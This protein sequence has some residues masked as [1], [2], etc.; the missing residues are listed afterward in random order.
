MYY[1]N[2]ASMTMRS[3]S[4]SFSYNLASDTNRCVKAKKLQF[5]ISS[6][7]ASNI[8]LI[9]LDCPHYKL[10]YQVNMLNNKQMMPP[11]MLQYV[12]SSTPPPL[13]SFSSLPSLPSTSLSLSTF[14]S[15]PSSYSSSSPPP[16]PSLYSLQSSASSSPLLRLIIASILCVSST[17]S[18][19]LRNQLT[20]SNEMASNLEVISK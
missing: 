19:L 12:T 8:H 15:T 4:N 9:W 17:T 1:H 13:M 10:S 11:S 3:L 7:H 14:V 16:T 20:A 5:F 18:C 6:F 2:L